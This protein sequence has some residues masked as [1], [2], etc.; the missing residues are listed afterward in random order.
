VRETVT[1]ATGR[2]SFADVQAGAFTLTVLAKG[3][4]EKSLSATLQTDESYEAPPVELQ[5]SAVTTEVRV[6][7]TR[8]E[9]AQEQLRDEEKQRVLGI[10]PNFNVVYVPDAPPLNGR[11]KF[12]LVWK[13]SVDPF[14]FVTTGMSAGMEQANNDLKGYGQG[15]A[16]YARRFGADYGDNVIGTVL[17]SAVLPAV[18]RQDPRYFYKGTGSRRAR[19]LYAIANSV[20]CKGDNGRWQPNYSRIIASPAAGAISNLYLPA[21]DRLSAGAIFADAAIGKATGAAENIFQEFVVKK[22]TPKTPVYAR[23]QPPNP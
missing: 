10:I 1:D 18:F 11:Q 2:F 19:V 14:T 6:T 7:A 23:K 12:E 22:L 13:M 17:G 4:E 16:G 21:G 5:A 15:A 9:V 20:I 3:F 8:E